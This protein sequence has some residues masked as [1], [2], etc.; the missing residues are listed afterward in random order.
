[1]Q[2]P[3]PLFDWPD[4][5]QPDL[6]EQSRADLV[7]R[8]ERLPPLSHRRIVLQARLQDLTAYAIQRSIGAI[9]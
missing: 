1:M 2:L 8:I 3:L 9:R 6:L 4:G 5:I 7:S